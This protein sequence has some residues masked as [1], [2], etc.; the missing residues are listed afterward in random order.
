VFRYAVSLEVIPSVTLTCLFT[1]LNSAFPVFRVF[2]V[3]IFV[4]AEACWMPEGLFALQTLKLMSSL[5][6]LVLR[7]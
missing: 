2:I 7:Q 3:G 6:A 5:G 1:A 4:A